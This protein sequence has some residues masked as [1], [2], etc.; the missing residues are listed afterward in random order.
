MAWD[1]EEMYWEQ[2]A[3]VNWLRAGDQNTKFFH[4]STIQR[5][6]RNKI[7]KIRDGSDVWHEKEEEIA[8]IFMNFYS[9]LFSSSNPPDSEDILEFVQCEISDEDNRRLMEPVSTLEIKSAVFQLGGLKAPGPDG[10]S[11][12]FYHSSWEV[13]GDDV[14]N[15]VKD[16]FAA[17]ID[18]TCLNDTNIVLIPKVE[19]AATVNHFRPIS[20]C[21]FSY[22]IISKVIVNRMKSLLPK[23]ISANQRAF[24]PGRLIQD[25]ILVAHEAF[26]YL[27]TKKSGKKYEMAIKVDMNLMTGLSGVL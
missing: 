1:K 11:G 6:K 24:V 12:Q 2:R 17:N 8:D 23:C 14:V 27:K 20:L 5:R 7:L 18:V 22:K 3:R 13:V 21:N 25:N 19:G 16:F 10:F 15:M 9:N 4:S 26:H